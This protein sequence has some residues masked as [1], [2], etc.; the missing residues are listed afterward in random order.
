MQARPNA[1][2]LA[3]E[4][5]KQALALQQAIDAAGLDKRLITLIQV[6]VSQING[7]AFCL[8]MHTHEAKRLG[9]SEMRLYVLPGWRES[10]LFSARERAL[11]AWAE[12]LTAIAHEGAPDALFDELRRHFSEVETV[13]ITG[14]VAMINFWN[15]MAIGMSVVSPYERRAPQ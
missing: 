6:R 15:R 7:C 4:L 3:P 14:A 13:V 2:E 1:Y 11:L 9:E 5:A 10:T 12:S 8:H